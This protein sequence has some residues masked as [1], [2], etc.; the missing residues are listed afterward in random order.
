MAATT[1][2]ATF[3]GVRGSIPTCSADVYRFGGESPCVE[4]TCGERVLVLDGG[5]G[6]R[7]LGLDLL[8]RGVGALDIFMTHLHYDHIIGL[9]FFKPFMIRGNRITMWAGPNDND[10]VLDEAM[11]SFMRAP[12]FPICPD[13]FAAEVHFR[14][15]ARNASI[16][17]GDGITVRTA[18][19]NHPGGANGYRIEFDGRVLSYVTDT[20][21]TPGTLDENVL[22]L[23]DEADLVI[24]DTSYTDDEMKDFPGFGHSSWQQGVR[25]CQAAGAKR[26]AGF[27]HRPTR[28]D[29]M[30]AAME[31]ELDAAL[32]G[33]FFARQDQRV[34]I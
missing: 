11:R 10:L 5:S 32:P 15:Y 28:T 19:L 7:R 13:I 23:I 24:Y 9:P 6:I 33:S 27:H 20:E 16:E 18:P 8:A 26:L 4:V 30:L 29:A 25:L 17:L 3:W 1:F 14:D 2:S 12:F 31:A 21:H 34:D 22:G